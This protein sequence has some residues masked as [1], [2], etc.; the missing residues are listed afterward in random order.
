MASR[1]FSPGTS[2]FSTNKTDRHDITEI[3]LKMALNTITLTIYYNYK[4]VYIYVLAMRKIASLLSLDGKHDTCCCPN[5]R[6]IHVR[7]IEREITNGQTRYTGNTGYTRHSSKTKNP[8]PETK[9]MSNTD[10]TKNRGWTRV[11]SKGK[12]FLPHIRQTQT[13]EIR[14]NRWQTWNK[15]FPRLLH[16]SITQRTMNKFIEVEHGVG[17]RIYKTAFCISAIQIFIALIKSK[18]SLSVNLIHW[19]MYQQYKYRHN[20]CGYI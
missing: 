14:H 12:Q 19:Y 17:K 4:I 6:L 11:L 13:T 2:V 15:I 18:R 3:L 8:T 10:P 7:N 9:K 20:I 1:W 5:N 16:N